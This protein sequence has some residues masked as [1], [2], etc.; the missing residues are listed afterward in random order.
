MGFM[1]STHYTRCCPYSSVY[2][3]GTTAIVVLVCNYKLVL[4]RMDGMARSS[5]RSPR[6]TRRW[7]E[8]DKVSEM[9]LLLS[10][11]ANSGGG[12][13]CSASGP[14][15]SSSFIM[16]ICWRCFCS[17]TWPTKQRR[18]GGKTEGLKQPSRG[19]WWVVGSLLVRRRQFSMK[20]RKVMVSAL[21]TWLH[22][23]CATT[24]IY[25]HL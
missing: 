12:K 22:S 15:S 3:Q 7:R 23:Q 4:G 24:P 8:T 18:C 25:I 11:G 20:W 10:V 2:G 14:A 6:S 1:R 9:S 16:T 13:V 5:S 19:G 21:R 17:C